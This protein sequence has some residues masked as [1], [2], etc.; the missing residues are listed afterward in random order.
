MTTTTTTTVIKF[1]HKEFCGHMI[2]QR[3]KDGYLNA[4]DMCKIN[5]K[6]YNDYISIDS[7]KEYLFFA[8]EEI[9]MN[10]VN[11][12]NIFFMCFNRAQAI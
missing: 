12:I 8:K 7:T 4:T 1:E 10:R 2:K 6:R 11:M 5:K 3:K 9:E